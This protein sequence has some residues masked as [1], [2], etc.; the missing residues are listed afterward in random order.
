MF[1]ACAAPSKFSLTE[2]E[3]ASIS[4]ANAYPHQSAQTMKLRGPAL[5]A[6]RQL[7]GDW[8]KVKM[9]WLSLLVH[10]GY[11]IQC[12]DKDGQKGAP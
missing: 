2:Q 10:P 7:K 12:T 1:Q 11:L 3:L 4:D 5:L 8:V 9:S 6:L